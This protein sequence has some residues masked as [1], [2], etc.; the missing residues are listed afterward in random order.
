MYYVF[1]MAHQAEGKWWQATL[2]GGAV[3]GLL[4]PLVGGILF[5]LLSPKPDG[6]SWRGVFE[7][8]AYFPLIWMYG[9]RFVGLPAAVLGCVCGVLLNSISAKCGSMR[10]AIIAAVGLGLVLGTAVPF[11]FGITFRFAHV[12]T[13]FAM[14]GSGAIAGLM[15]GLLML[16]LFH[17]SGWLHLSVNNPK[18]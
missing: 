6:W 2:L 11:G 14:C 4:G 15:C 16:W 12:Q 18:D 10:S 17:Q 9:I 8:I 1:D 3:C 7:I 13:N 5:I